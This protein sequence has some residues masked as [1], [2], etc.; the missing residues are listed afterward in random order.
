M[1]LSFLESFA[2]WH[3]KKLGEADIEGSNV[4]FCFILY[5]PF[6]QEVAEVDSMT[7]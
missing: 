1:S 5:S 2:V 7:N 4:D 3:F 6:L